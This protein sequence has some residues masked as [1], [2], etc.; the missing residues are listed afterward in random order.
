MNDRQAEGVIRK[1]LSGF[2]YVQVGEEEVTCRARGKFR[3]KKIVPL[4]GDRVR[5]TC[6]PDGSGSLDEILPRRNAFQRPAVANIDQLVIIA[7]G[8]IPVSDPFLLDRI[9]SL[10]ES[11]GCQPILCVN[12][13]DL[14]PARD[15]LD[16]Y[17]AA[18]IPTL[19]VSAVTGQGIEELRGLLAG[20]ISAFTG[21]SGVGKSSILNALDP[22]F[23]LAT[24]E[25]SEKLGRG[26]H[27][28][29]HVELFPVAGGL[30]AD[31][32]GFSAFD[33]EKGGEAL[34]K[35][36]LAE[37]FRE[38]R[39]YLGQCQFVGCAHVKEKGCAV[40][41]AVEE[42]KISPSRHRSYVRL[43]TLAKEKKP[44]EKP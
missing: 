33:Q 12:K 16:L 39:P 24:G 8:A 19:A 10:A 22:A 7:S 29:R 11:K 40:L 26:R 6:Q 14:V 20:K 5:I 30:I 37:T 32:P 18:G 3:H 38:F 17:Q 44:W 35:D 41:A 21:N 43:Y 4:V 13:W 23:S 34:D 2:Y 36:T 15:L 28:T 1:A 9:I 31:T 42:G 27:T 25:I